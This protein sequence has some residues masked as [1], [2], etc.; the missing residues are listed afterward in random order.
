MQGESEVAQSCLTLCYP[1][2]CSLPG[3]SVRGIFQARVLEWIAISFSRGSSQ[4][5]NWTRVSCIAGTCFTIWATREAP[6]LLKLSY[7][8]TYHWSW[9]SLQN[10]YGTQLTVN[11]LKTEDVMKLCQTV[12]SSR[13]PKNCHLVKW[14]MRIHDVERSSPECH[15]FLKMTAFA[16]NVVSGAN[17]TKP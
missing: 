10:Q 4:P 2:D 3:S 8:K 13:H 9:T 17:K 14:D 15:R 6:L 5:R 7:N 12:T 16:T 11:Y 1:M